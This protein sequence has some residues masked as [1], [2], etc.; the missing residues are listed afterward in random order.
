MI[1]EQTRKKDQV[2]VWQ[3][4]MNSYDSIQDF[5]K[6]ASSLEHLNVAVLNAGVYMVTYQQSKYGWEQT[7]QVN[8]LSTA[9][10]VL[11]LLPKLR[12]SQTR[13]SLPVLEIVSSRNYERATL[14]S[15]QPRTDNLLQSY[16][17]ANGCKA[18][19][20]YAVSKLL[21]MCVMQMLASFARSP[22]AGG[23]KLDVVVTSVCPGYCK[24]D[25][26]RGHNSLAM[27]VARAIANMLFLRATEEGSRSLVSAVTLGEE[28]HRALWA[29]DEL[30]P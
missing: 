9:L 21:V 4:D 7:L 3:L 13:N 1:E 18:S 6:R 2:E 27:K 14:P 30:K 25:R 23:G 20:E 16:N 28:A 24:S 26:S 17:T 12:A 15:Q 5:A 10:L 29:D 8:V 19:Q 11:L 22:E